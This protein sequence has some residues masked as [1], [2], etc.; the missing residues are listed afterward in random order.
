MTENKNIIHKTVIFTGYKCNNN[1]I[2]CMEANKRN[3]PVRSTEE[4]KQEMVAARSRGSNYLE[5]IGGET[6]IRTDFIEL[7]KF[8]SSL[9]FST[10]MIA[11]NGRMFSY[12]KIAEDALLAGLNSI[13]F[14]I[15][16]HNAEIHDSLTRSPG[17]FD[18][19]IVG[20]KNIYRISKKLGLNVEIGSNTCIVKPNYKYLP[21]IG[22]LIESFNITNS[23]FIFVDC[24]EGGAFNNFDD[25]VP[26]ISEIAPYARS[27]LDMGK[28]KGHWHIRYV[29]LCYFPDHSNQISE[30]H[31]V[32]TFKTEH[33]AQDFIN[34]DVEKSRKEIGRMKIERCKECVL[35]NHC[36]GIWKKYIDKYG[37]KELQPVKFF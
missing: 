32:S 28:E 23:E 8:A 2:F 31:E 30:L 29:P 4:I 11:S 20:I 15:H 12:E 22:S 33:I 5:L 19:L 16:G 37:D 14:S 10:V 17:S 7:I 6:S 25:L 36:E 24:N 13:V 21:E 34:L 1:C 3:L 9:K 18:Q 26:R 27:C 35:V